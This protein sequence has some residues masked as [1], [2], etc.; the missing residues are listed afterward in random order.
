[1]RYLFITGTYRSGTT[2]VD[3]LLTNHNHGFVASQP[4][5]FLYILLKE[6][7]NKKMNF[8]SKPYAINPEFAVNCNPQQFN[9]FL[10]NN[11]ITELFVKKALN[12][13]KG[14]S[15]CSTPEIYNLIET[16]KNGNI[17]DI[18]KRLCDNLA[19]TFNEKD[20]HFIGSKE[21][22][23]EDYIPYFINKGVKVIHLIRD[24]RDI[25]LSANFSKNSGYVGK[26]RPI[27]YTLQMWR[28]SVSF[29]I[30]NSNNPNLFILKYEDLVLNPFE[31]LN[32]LTD[33]I[34]TNRFDLEQFKNGINN[35]Y[36]EK[37]KGNSSFN[38]Y[39]FI[40][41][42]SIYRYKSNLSNDITTY[43]NNI[44]G[45]E[46]KYMG[47]NEKINFNENT[48]SEF[49]EPDYEINSLFNTDFSSSDS[50]I[51]KE[52][53]RYNLLKKGSKDSDLIKSYFLFESTFNKL[54]SLLE[55]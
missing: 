54:K 20:L 9:D 19:E 43:I 14:Y 33:F 7:Y 24:P 12:D 18:Y 36:G 30:N 53:H 50:S 8:N 3:K 45:P 42:S 46:L 55:K 5:P 39:N 31:M 44:C 1:M 22:I 16:L 13:M 48:I 10:L 41:T 26:N 51:S 2:L 25:V 29:A 52:L 32:E 35:Q 40:D 38:D 15:G 23:S 37:W 34:G 47:Y 6:L 4:F 17:V 11:N 21:I 27:L 28:K 49:R